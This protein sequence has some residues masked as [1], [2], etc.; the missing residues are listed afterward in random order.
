MEITIEE[1]IWDIE[2]RLPL[3]KAVFTCDG[4]KVTRNLFILGDTDKRNS[5]VDIIHLDKIVIEMEVEK[6]NTL[7][8]EELANLLKEKAKQ[9]DPV[10]CFE[11]NVNNELPFFK[12]PITTRK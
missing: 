8:A 1:G 9:K 3:R 4:K 7:P 10:G 11:R 6:I 2:E 12:C 5:K